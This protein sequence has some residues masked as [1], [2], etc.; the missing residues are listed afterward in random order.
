MQIIVRKHYI[1]TIKGL[2]ENGYDVYV[3]IADKKCSSWW[4]S[5][6]E[7]VNH[8]DLNYISN[9][10]YLI[11]TE[12]RMGKFKKLWEEINWDEVNISEPHIIP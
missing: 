5:P 12:K 11:N 7:S 2:E 8:A 1:N 10:Y 4:E 9:R 6:P 3:K